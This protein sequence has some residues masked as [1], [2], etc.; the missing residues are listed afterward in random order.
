MQKVLVTG[1]SGF[2]GTHVTRELSRQGVPVI[3]VC[4]KL[5]RPSPAGCTVVRADLTMAPQIEAVFSDHDVTAVI[6]CAAYGV[7]YC[8]QDPLRAVETNVAAS[9]RLFQ[10]ADAAGVYPFIHVGSSYEYG[11]SESNITEDTPLR[12]RGVYG[13]SKAAA[14]MLLQELGSRVDH[15]PIIARLFSM[16]GP[17]DADEKLVPLVVNA[18][19]DG[20]P[21]AMTDGTEIRDYQYV[22]DVARQLVFL[23]MLP[24]AEIS[25]CAVLNI[26]SGDAITIRDIASRVADYFGTAHLLEFGAIPSRPG[27]VSRNVGDPSK[28]RQLAV[29]HGRSELLSPTPLERALAIMT[30]VEE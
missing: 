27:T 17:G 22:G 3:G 2:L 15:G 28:F 25:A 20:K 21:L 4:R 30:R 19:R 13:A 18:S 1:C 10:M 16:F 26:A 14:S 24:P 11:N 9:I 23:S 7:A 6:H 8:Q 12:P 5:R 29:R